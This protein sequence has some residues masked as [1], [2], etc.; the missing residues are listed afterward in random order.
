MS[1]DYPPCNAHGDNGC[2]VQYERS[3]IHASSI[4]VF[5]GAF[6]RGGGG[7]DLD[8]LADMEGQ[9]DR[10]GGEGEFHPW[11][12]R[13]DDFGERGVVDLLDHRVR[14]QSGRVG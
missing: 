6:V 4:C 10:F 11:E 5:R 7:A 3:D 13:F 14:P 1:S 9:G 2:T 12:D 8:R